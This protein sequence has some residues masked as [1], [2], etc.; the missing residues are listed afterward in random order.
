MNQNVFKLFVNNRELQQKVA[1]FNR[2]ILRYSESHLPS[3]PKNDCRQ[4]LQ[5]TKETRE[6]RR[7][8]RQ[9]VKNIEQ[10]GALIGAKT[11]LKQEL[12]QHLTEMSRNNSNEI[13]KR[14]GNIWTYDMTAGSTNVTSFILSS[15]SRQNASVV[16]LSELDEKYY[17]CYVTAH[18][19]NGGAWQKILGAMTPSL[20][21]SR[22]SQ[23]VTALNTPTALPDYALHTDYTRRTGNH[24]C[25]GYNLSKSEMSYFGTRALHNS[26]TADILT[27][28]DIVRNGG[29]VFQHGQ[30]LTRDNELLRVSHCHFPWDKEERQERQNAVAK[31]AKVT[32]EQG[33]VFTISDIWSENYYHRLIDQGVKLA[34]FAE[35]LKQRPRMLVHASVEATSLVRQLL[36]VFGLNNRVV[37]GVVKASVIFRPHSS[38]CLWPNFLYTRTANVMFRR[39]VEKELL[40]EGKLYPSTDRIILF[41]KR[42]Y[43]RITNHDEVTSLAQRLAERTNRQLVTFDDQKLPSLNETMT[44][45][46]RADV[47]IGVHGAGLANLIF[48]RPGTTLVEFS[49]KVRDSSKCF[50]ILGLQLGL[51]C[52]GTETTS[53]VVSKRCNESGIDV[54]ITELT[55]V[56]DYVASYV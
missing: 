21:S 13:R 52:Y 44:L 41:I 42:T 11:W 34:A 2:R 38:G 50:R 28:L 14:G 36:P 5:T 4:P 17:D 46:Y 3:Q 56:L 23:D 24:M 15:L 49:C 37:S 39:Y 8:K 7:F 9:V 33:E 54:N 16:E 40:G 1:M 26:Q 20:C 19:Q 18:V 35:F 47:V 43:R 22:C 27:S 30:I 6:I 31:R 51:R 10:S 32:C 29:V 55:N 12:M 53:D 45:F 25:N 48:S